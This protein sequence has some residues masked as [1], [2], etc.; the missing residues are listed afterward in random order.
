MILELDVWLFL[1]LKA[2][3]GYQV[4]D[5]TD[6]ACVRGSRRQLPASMTTTP[7]AEKKMCQSRIAEK[8]V[9]PVC[10]VV[11]FVVAFWAIKS[12]DDGAGCLAD[13]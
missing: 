12:L 13:S 5:P 8:C 11:P 6:V 10:D 4:L 3:S 9:A 2:K 1:M 7:P